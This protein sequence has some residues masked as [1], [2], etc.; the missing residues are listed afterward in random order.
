MH[1]DVVIEIVVRLVAAGEADADHGTPNS[2]SPKNP[3]RAIRNIGNM[4]SRKI[5]SSGTSS[6]VSDC[7]RMGAG[8]VRTGLIGEI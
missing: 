5:G 7:R 4:P 6:N 3:S 1:D 2:A 8:P